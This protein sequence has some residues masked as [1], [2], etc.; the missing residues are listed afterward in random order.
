MSS[1]KVMVGMSGGVDSSVAAA[2]LLERGYDVIGITMHMWED[3]TAENEDT[4]EDSCCSLSAVED[5]RRVANKLSIPHYVINFKDIFKKTIVDYFIDEYLNGKTPNPCIACNKFIKFGIFIE[6]ALSMN[7]DYVATGH[8]A[9]IEYDNDRKRYL[10]KK[11]VTKEKDQSYVLYNIPKD[12]LCKVLFPIGD[13][14][15]EEVRNIA[16]KYEL[17]IATKPDSQEIC[18]IQDN[19]YA[20]FIKRMSKSNIKPGYFV[21]TNGNI[22]GEHKGIINYTVGQRKGLGV[23]FGKPMY[24]VRIDSK[25]NQIVLGEADE[26][27]SNE[28]IAHDLNYLSI[29]TLEEPIKVNAKIRYS[30]KESSATIYPL[31]NNKVKVIFEQPQRAVTPGQSIVFYDGDIVV[32]GGIIATL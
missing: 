26:L 28:L 21:D 14:V 10:L 8:Y 12:N 13:Y 1:Q 25:K 18:F 9:R 5:A 7:V 15:K 30:A 16:R 31:E 4:R 6:K 20:G 11:A 19:D 3:P 17:P 32:G 24:V 27:F 22:L 23:T 2:L 29:D